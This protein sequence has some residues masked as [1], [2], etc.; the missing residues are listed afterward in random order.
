MPIAS[1]SYIIKQ[2]HSHP[3]G[4]LCCRQTGMVCSLRLNQENLMDVLKNLAEVCCNRLSKG[5]QPH[6]LSIDQGPPR[7]HSWQA[8]VARSSQ[9]FYRPNPC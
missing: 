8:F 7:S 2:T 5:P 9:H 4:A 1:Y 3:C 6:G